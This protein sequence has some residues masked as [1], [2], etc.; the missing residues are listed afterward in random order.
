MLSESRTRDRKY[1][2]V[3]RPVMFGA[4]RRVGSNVQD[5]PLEADQARAVLE[6]PRRV[7]FSTGPHRRNDMTRSTWHRPF[8]HPSAIALL[9]F[10]AV[11]LP[12]A[13]D[14]PYQAM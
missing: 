11:A 10:C 8:S 13:Q 4:C 1:A 7:Y 6:T 2:V 3:Q 9:S 5:L 14:G 12:H